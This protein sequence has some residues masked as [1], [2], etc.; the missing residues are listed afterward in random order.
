MAM[1]SKI[2]DNITYY[3]EERDDAVAGKL[4]RMHDWCNV[5]KGG[6][7]GWMPRPQRFAQAGDAG[8]D[9]TAQDNM[10]DTTWDHLEE[11]NGTFGT[12]GGMQIHGFCEMPIAY[13]RTKRG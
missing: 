7:S 2:F 5:S 1:Q 11:W 6:I 4:R 3:F 10:V 9:G 13:S 8:N 12:A